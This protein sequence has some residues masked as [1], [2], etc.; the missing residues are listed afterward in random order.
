VGID[1]GEDVLTPYKARIRRGICP[2]GFSAQDIS[3]SQATQAISDYRQAVGDSAGIAELC[4]YFC[5]SCAKL[6]GHCYVDD[7]D[8]YDALVRAFEH[9]LT[10]MLKLEPEQQ[11]PLV[12]RV[13]ALWGE[14]HHWGWGVVED[15]DDLLTAFGFLK[16]QF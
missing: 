11:A 3:I 12:E 5:E 1:S 7:D 8:Y 2:D 6:L 10:A 13:L 4:V 14:A 16:K 15:M 9:A